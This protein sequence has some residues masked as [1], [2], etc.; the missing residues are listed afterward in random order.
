MKVNQS[1][2]AAAVLAAALAGCES[3]KEEAPSRAPPVEDTAF[4]DMVGA[5]DKAR[6]AEDAVRQHKESLDEAIAESERS[7]AR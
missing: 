3:S 2:L 1:V 7:D 4:G 5:M 6:A